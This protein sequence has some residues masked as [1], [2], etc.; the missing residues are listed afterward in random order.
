MTPRSFWLALSSV[1]LMTTAALA[2]DVLITFDDI[3]PGPQ[4]PTFLASYG[5][6]GISW[7][8]AGGALGPAV[9]NYTGA[10]V[11]LASQA[12]GLAQ[13]WSSLDMSQPHWLA[14]DFSPRLTSFAL[15]RIGTTGGGSTDAWQA[16]FYD[17]ANNFLGS[18]GDGPLIDPAVA[19]YTFQAPY[20]LTIGRM[21]LESTWTGF[22]TYRNIPVDNFVLSQVPEPGAFTLLLAGGTGLVLRRRTR[23]A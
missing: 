7:G 14:F 8:G 1:V 4:G 20:G 3:T 15:T 6:P 16:R 10:P 22:A 13:G 19:Q 17:A 21:V 5:I 23:R 9:V 12:N 18:F 2:G 11:I